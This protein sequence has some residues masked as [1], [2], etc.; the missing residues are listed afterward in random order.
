MRKTVVDSIAINIGRFKTR[1]RNRRMLALV[2]LE[3]QFNSRYHFTTRELQSVGNFS[4]RPYRTKLT[5][6]SVE[7]FKSQK[8]E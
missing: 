8:V 5:M 6:H 4:M 3:R 1:K 7:K 2:I